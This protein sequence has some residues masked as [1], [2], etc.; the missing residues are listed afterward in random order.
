SPTI[1][2]HPDVPSFPTRRSSDLGFTTGGPIFK[3]KLFFFV[4]YEGRRLHSPTIFNF[5]VPTP[6]LQAGILRFRDASGNVGTTKLKIVGRSEEHTS[7]L[8]SPDHL[9]CRPLL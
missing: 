3:N 5:V 6:S 7:E 2:A 4:N 1:L 8:Q 9:V